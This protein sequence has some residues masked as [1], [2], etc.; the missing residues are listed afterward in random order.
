MAAHRCKT[1][2]SIR[3]ALF[4]DNRGHGYLPDIDDILN[5]MTENWVVYPGS[6]RHSM[7]LK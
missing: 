1:G 6:A 4:P 3:M 2:K 7:T 5:H